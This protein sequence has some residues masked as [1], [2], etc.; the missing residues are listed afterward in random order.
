MYTSKITNK[1]IKVVIANEVKQSR[2]KY[3][4]RLLHFIRNDVQKALKKSGCKI[5][6][7]AFLL[8]ALRQAQ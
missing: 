2:T 5:I 4:M 7:T 1:F 3:I 6:A 8:F